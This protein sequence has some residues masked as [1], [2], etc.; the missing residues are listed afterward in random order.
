MAEEKFYSVKFVGTEG[1]VGAG[2]LQ[3]YREEGNTGPLQ[4][5]E[6]LEVPKEVAVSLLPGDAWEAGEGAKT[7]EKEASKEAAEEAGGESQG[8]SE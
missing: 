8:G 5:G 2:E 6:T 1:A 4:V 3:S 7:L